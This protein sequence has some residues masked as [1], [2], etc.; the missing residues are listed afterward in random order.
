M[1]KFFVTLLTLG[2]A[3]LSPPNASAQ[4]GGACQEVTTQTAV[5]GDELCLAVKTYGAIGQPT[6]ALVIMLHGD[7]SNGGP[8]DYIAKRAKMVA[9]EA[10]STIVVAMARPGYGFGDGATSTGTNHGRRD[11]YTSVN[12]D[13]VADAVRRLKDR[14][15]PAR[16]VLVGHSGGAAIAGVIAGR[17]PGTADGYV[18]LACPCNIQAWRWSANRRAWTNSLSPSD[19]V[20]GVPPT[21]SIIAVTGTYDENTKEKIAED[22]VEQLVAAGKRAE[23]IPARG[24]GHNVDDAFWNAGARD[25]ILKAIG[26]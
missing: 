7:L 13:A 20:D 19:F 8:A 18:L 5:R 4:D 9:D 22:Y 12:V 3:A 10:P 15:R 17:H 25:S 11:S 16:T 14:Y 1:L 23:Y 26:M 24:A 6:R 2:L 21:A